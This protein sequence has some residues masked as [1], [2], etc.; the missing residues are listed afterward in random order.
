[1]VKNRTG[2]I[3]LI[4]GDI[5]NPFFSETAKVIITNARQRGIDVIISDTDYD[6][7]I[8]QNALSA[9]LARRVDGILIASVER[10]DPN[11]D[12]LV[13][14][15][16]PIILY[17][18]KTD[19]EKANYVVANNEYGACMAVEHLI[20]LGHKKICFLSGSSKYST[21]YQRLEGYKSAL[22]KHGIVFRQQFV[23]EQN[24]PEQGLS[25]YINQI[26]QH[27]EGPTAFFAASDQLAIQTM[28]II[29][30]NG[31]SVPDDFSVVGFDD[32]GISSNPFIGL[33]TVSQQTQIMASVALDKLLELINVGASGT[34]R[35][36]ILLNTDLIVRKTT[37]YLSKLK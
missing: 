21:F 4:V 33:T 22:E 17:N 10:E 24:N 26:V 16:F 31:Y 34:S 12:R 32:I 7:V 3:G 1:L 36:N 37:S 35:V 9:M 19:N 20:E 23:Y 5:A 6:K 14:N 8:M 28:N 13:E 2:T 15:E 18:R 27:E 30:Q 11:I 25:R 29:S